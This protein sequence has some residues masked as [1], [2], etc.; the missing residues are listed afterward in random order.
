MGKGKAVGKDVFWIP[1]STCYGQT[2]GLLA[3][4]A[5]CRIEVFDCILCPAPPQVQ[6]YTEHK[7][8]MTCSG[9][10]DLWWW[11]ASQVEAEG[12]DGGSQSTSGACPHGEMLPLHY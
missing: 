8:G 1:S 9:P 12:G 4:G 2:Q 7:T 10:T 5:V 3:M 6:R 11:P